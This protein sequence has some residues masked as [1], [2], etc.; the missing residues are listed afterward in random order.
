M[1]VAEILPMHTEN[2]V[3]VAFD[4]MRISLNEFTWAYLYC[5]V[6][7]KVVSN[8]NDEEKANAKR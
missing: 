2:Q 4:H 3:L 6:F 7:V 1:K 5:D 8:E